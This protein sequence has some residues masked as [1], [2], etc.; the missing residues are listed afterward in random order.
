MPLQRHKDDAGIEVLE[1]ELQDQDSIPAM[2]KVVTYPADYTL[3]G[4][5]TQFDKKLIEFP[6][7]Q[8]KF[9]WTHKQASRLIESFLLGLPVHAIFLYKDKEEKQHVIDGQ[10][11]LRSI[12]Y[13]FKG[14]FGEELK[15]KKTIFRLIGLDENSPYVNKT[16]KDLED[17]D[18]ASFNRL[19]NSVLRSFVIQQ[20]DPADNSSIYHIFER[21]NT[22]GTL[23]VG[24]EI[25][26]CVYAGDFNNLLLKL[27]KNETWRE[28]FGKKTE[29]TRLRDVELILRFFA[30][31]RSKKY[32]KPMKTFLNNFMGARKKPKVSRLALYRDIFETTVT[33]VHESLGPTPFHLH[34]GLNAAAFD[35]VFVAFARHRRA[36][37]RDI[38]TRFKALKK[39]AKFIE[40]V[41]SGTTDEHFIRQRLKRAKSVLFG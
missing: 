25:R 23:L 32:S 34:A 39:D 2:Y 29:D 35:A 30:L 28:I 14:H 19:N 10:Q 11:R 5:V 40:W 1:S 26:N 33:R 22:G 4:L 13:F 16:Y 9:V 15:G 21:L 18:P 6:S 27:N 24:Q 8:R 7:F 20:L 31:L 37:P 12:F 17:N 41:T 36:I 3:E 38:A